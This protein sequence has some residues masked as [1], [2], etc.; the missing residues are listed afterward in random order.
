MSRAAIACVLAIAACGD[1]GSVTAEPL[2]GAPAA[3]RALLATGGDVIVIGGTSAF[4][5]DQLQRYRDGRWTVAAGVPPFGARATLIEGD[6]VYAASDTAIYRLDDVAAFRWSDARAIPPPVPAVIGALG[7]TILGAAPDDGG[8]AVVAW[9]PGTRVWHELA[10]PLGT[11]ARGFLVG[12][13][14]V[15]WTD[16]ALGVLRAEAGAI[17]LLTDCGDCVVPMLAV[18]EDAFVACGTSS[19]PLESFRL[20]GAGIALP[21]GL[22]ACVA[23]SSGGGHGLLVTLD[24]VLDLPPAAKSWNRVTAAEPG[25]S[26]IHA[27]SAIYAYGDGISARG[28]FVLDL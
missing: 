24:A 12:D 7:D 2:P 16:P 23:A 3:V 25:S 20:G 28:V 5:L 1:D 26:Y 14:H 10:R 9:T 8:G 19:P 11:G 17:T 13:G 18:S 22:T 27:G 21:D 15:T 4:G 6:A